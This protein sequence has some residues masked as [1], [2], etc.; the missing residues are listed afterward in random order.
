MRHKL[1]AFEAMNDKWTCF[2]SSLKVLAENVIRAMI[3][4]PPHQSRLITDA[5]SIRVKVQN[6]SNDFND[7]NI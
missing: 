3:A 1:V 4:P 7:F 2:H 6:E 5:F